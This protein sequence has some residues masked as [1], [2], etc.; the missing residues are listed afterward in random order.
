MKGMFTAKERSAIKPADVVIGFQLLGMESFVR[1]YCER[2]VLMPDCAFGIL[3][4]NF[5][6]VD[7]HN[8]I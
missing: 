2:Y 4:R 1:E 6:S 7:G 3:I 5:F 8:Y